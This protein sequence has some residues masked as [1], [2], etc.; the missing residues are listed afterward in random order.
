MLVYGSIPAV[1]GLIFDLII[2]VASQTEPS[3]VK[4]F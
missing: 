3:E 1:K 4:L 2:W